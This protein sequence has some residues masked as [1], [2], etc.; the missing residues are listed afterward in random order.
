MKCL[1]NFGGEEGRGTVVNNNGEL[2]QV[3]C[4]LNEM[5]V[6]NIFCKIR[7]IHK[8]LCGLRVKREVP[9]LDNLPLRH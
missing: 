1:V 9:V 2:A 3:L 6:C 8:K 7:E 5:S 4:V